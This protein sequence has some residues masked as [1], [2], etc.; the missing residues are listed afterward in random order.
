MMKALMLEVEAVARS[1]GVSLD[2]DIVEKTMAF[3]DTVDPR[4][5]A[6]MQLDVETGRVFELEAVVGAIGRKGRA[7]NLPTPTVDMVYAALLPAYLKAQKAA[8]LA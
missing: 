3:I 4:I 8:A 5:K 1:Q 7:A 2:V 6:S